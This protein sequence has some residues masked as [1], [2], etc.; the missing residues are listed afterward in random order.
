MFTVKME[1]WITDEDG[2]G[3]GLHEWEA[4]FDTLH[5]ALS[6]VHSLWVSCNDLNHQV[7]QVYVYPAT[8]VSDTIGEGVSF[9]A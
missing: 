2:L 6:K 7:N 1:Y 5:E 4:D 9:D 3:R 8:G